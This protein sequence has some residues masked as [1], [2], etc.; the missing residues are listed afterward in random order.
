MNK[1]TLLIIFIAGVILGALFALAFT[2]QAMAYPYLKIMGG[3]GEGET[4]SPATPIQISNN[5]VN[6]VAQVVQS[7]QVVPES[8]EAAPIQKEATT[9]VAL[10]EDTVKIQQ[11]QAEIEALMQQIIA[12]QKQ[13]IIKL[14]VI[15][16]K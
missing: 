16:T 5:P 11:L 3:D 6:P 9:T 12:L 8:A 7:A 14:Q 4:D 1:L 10:Q 15:Q 2:E 13:L